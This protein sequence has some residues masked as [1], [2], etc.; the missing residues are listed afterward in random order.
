M[1]ENQKPDLS[2]KV[3][4]ELCV[5]V[6]DYCVK[7]EFLFKENYKNNIFYKDLFYFMILPQSHAVI[8]ASMQR[9][10]T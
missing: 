3:N 5:I 1:H 4:V 2:L 9:K 6:L 10:D 8:N 7:K